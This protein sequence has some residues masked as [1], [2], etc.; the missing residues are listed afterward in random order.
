[1]IKIVVAKYEPDTCTEEEAELL[2]L[3]DFP[4]DYLREFILP[5]EYDGFASYCYSLGEHGI[6]YRLFK[7]EE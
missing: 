6:K 1:M 4:Q 5:E 3:W 7:K 2:G